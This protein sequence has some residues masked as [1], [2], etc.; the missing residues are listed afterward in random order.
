MR[1]FSHLVLA[2][3]AAA[4]VYEPPFALHPGDIV[5]HPLPTL[6]KRKAF[7]PC[8][9]VAELWAAQK[10]Q[11]SK[12]GATPAPIRVPAQR[13]YDCLM[14]V[15]VDVEGDLK[16]VEELE[17]YIQYQSTLSWLKSG[18]KDQLDP[19]DIMGIFGSL[20]S[21]I[22]GKKDFISDYQVQLTI[23]ATL[24]AAGDFHLHYIPDITNIFQFARPNGE[25]VS[26]SEDGV[27]LPKL[28]LASDLPKDANGKITGSEITKINGKIATEAIQEWSNHTRYHDADARYNTIFPNPALS[29]LGTP[30][31]GLSYSHYVYAGPSTNYTFANNSGKTI[32]NVAV[33]PAIY[34]F[35][36]VTDGVSFFKAFCNGP[37]RPSTLSSAKRSGSSNASPSSKPN[38]VA[39]ATP[40]PSP[41]LLGY[42]KPEFIHDSKVVSGY[43]MSGNE[44]KDV[45]VL[46]LPG[47][48]PTSV[49]P[50]WTQNINTGGFVETQ[51]LVRKFF[52][53]AVKQNKKKLVIDLRGN[54]GGTIDM[55][56]EL[57]KQLFPAIE[58]YGAAR[59]RAHDAFHYYSALVADVA[60]E[61]DDKDG[62]V[63]V[64]WDDADYGIQSTFLW[65]NI[66][67]ENLKPYK[68]YR[69]YYGPETING[70]TFT[71]Q[72]RYNVSSVDSLTGY[73]EFKNAPAQPFKPED[74]VILQDG[75]CGSTCAI[76][77]ELMREQGKVQSIAIGGRPRNAAMQGIG[78]SKGSQVLT[79][80][81]LH[82]FAER[83]I[84]VAE[85][86][87]GA[88]VAKRLNETTNVGKIY[89]AK[90]IF[91]RTTIP[92][93]G[94]SIVGG[95]NSLNNQRQG[96][97][98]ETP[99]EFI[100]EAT[101][102]R[103]FYTTASYLDPVN[104]WK[105][106]I[107]SRWGKGKCVPG[108]TG[109]K[110]AISTL[111]NKSGFGSKGTNSQ[112][113]NADGTPFQTTGAA[114]SMGVSAA[115]MVVAGAFAMVMAL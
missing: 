54:G 43:Y 62:K 7:S 8:G 16:E 19:H 111:E 71:S 66:L 68:A 114:P 51:G 17:S 20:K 31:G 30:N 32:E 2:A 44:Y 102:C 50:S 91:K 60:L 67:D 101:D 22:K 88:A 73:N 6:S 97:T 35:S 11:L 59:Y 93:A 58:P 108:S 49:S 40:R 36:K 96:D 61:G 80:D 47:F 42:P 5:D 94:K 85:A 90:Q 74:I 104:L 1:S 45:A 27:S 107:D 57:F 79:F 98:T 46:V 87:D 112:Q 82:D 23:R 12:P 26:I 99:L 64:K 100:Y 14:T 38:T 77:S 65:S 9:E 56:F 34:D 39:S 75:F 25:L 109:H 15:P 33:I 13:A 4:Q 76:F 10:A 83:T 115:M 69:D 89:N 55:G 29:A 63:G 24:D 110:T 106:A 105:M 48:A 86:L 52:A 3:S 84:K 103:L 41:A 18:V 81:V 78:G 21:A 37:T 72:R 53:D 28:Y 92:G 113:S 95:V 70:D